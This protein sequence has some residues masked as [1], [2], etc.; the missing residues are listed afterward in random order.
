MA[1]AER[2]RFS[3]MHGAGNDFVVLDLR[4]GSPPP[5]AALAA[6]LADRHRGVGCDQILTIEP[7]RSAG[8]V[9]AYR[10]WNADGS[11]S[12]QCGN[13]ARCVAAWLVRDGAARGERFVVDSPAGIHQVQ[14]LGDDRYAVDMGAPRFAPA[15]VPLAGFEA[16]AAEYALELDGRRVVFGA[17]SMGNPHAVIEVGDVGAADV[18]G[19]GAAL[20]ASPA[21]PQSV[22]VGFAQVLAPDHV[23][24][25]V[26]ERGVG[27]TLACGSGACAAVAA[28]VRRGRIARQATVSLPGGDL[29]IGWAADDA[30][31]IMAGPAAFVF[32]GEWQA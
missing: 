12:G 30:P 8:A 16:E 31:I 27:E 17:V 11:P 26:Y 23:R 15:A 2:L 25:R 28:L 1:M 24:L 29:R 6:R 32:E 10:I 14:V 7:P 13:G 3:K 22:N 5:D 18:A 20:Q 4:D 9:A 21:F 19:L